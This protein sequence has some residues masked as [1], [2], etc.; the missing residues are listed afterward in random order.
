M[1]GSISLAWRILGE[2]QVHRRGQTLA[3]RIFR[4]RISRFSAFSTAK[5]PARVALC[6]ALPG[7]TKFI[8]PMSRP[9]EER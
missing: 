5:S 6:N 8:G 4:Q 3:I 1:I 9:K 7:D 2:G